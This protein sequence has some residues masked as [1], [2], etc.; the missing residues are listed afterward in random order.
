MAW[1]LTAAITGLSRLQAGTSIPGG[2]ESRSRFGEGLVTGSEIAP[3]R[4]RA[5]HR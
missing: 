4:R 1:P 3:R 5:V 2:A